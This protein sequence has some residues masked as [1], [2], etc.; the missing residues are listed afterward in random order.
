MIIVDDQ[1]IFRLPLRQLLESVNMEVIAEASD[2]PT[3][4]YL[5]RSYQ[6]EFIIVDVVLPGI[7]GIQGTPLLLQA[8]P[9]SKIYLISSYT[10]QEHI[11]AEAAKQVGAQG[12]CLKDE[13]NRE[14]MQSWRDACDQEGGKENEQTDK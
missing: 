6:P 13:L 12:F 3:A 11:F 7:N 8:S 2:I 10:D 5:A 14:L 4:L 9:N 1:P